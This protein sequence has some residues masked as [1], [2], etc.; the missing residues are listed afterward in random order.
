MP[1]VPISELQTRATTIITAIAGGENSNRRVGNLLLD[2]IDT[3][4]AASGGGGDVFGPAS[5]L[6]NTVVLFDGTTGKLIQDSGVLLSDIGSLA[7]NGLQKIGNTISVL[8]DGSTISV[9]G[10]G[11]K[12]ADGGI[13]DLQINASAA[14]AHSKLANLAGLSVLGRST[15]SSGAMAAITGTDGQA[16]RVSGT[17]LGF[18][19]LASG[20]LGDGIVT[21]AKFQDI[22]TDRLLGRDTAS[23]GDVEEISLDSTLE[24][25][26]SASIRRA[27]LT[28]DVT[29]SAG[30]NATTIANN[31]VTTVKI[32]DA[33][34]TL[35]KLVNLAGLS[36]LGRSANS[37]GVM[38]AI[39]GTDGQVLRVSGTTLG[40]GTIAT[41]GLADGSVT[42]AKLANGTACSLLGR[43]ANS[44]GVYADISAGTNGF[45]FLR[46]SNAVTAALLLDENVD[47]AA[48]VAG[49]KINPDFGGQTIIT[50]GGMRIGTNPADSGSI[51]IAND[52]SLVWRNA[53]NTG[54]V[55]GIRV[56][57]SD[58]VSLGTSS[59][60]LLTSSLGAFSG[61]VSA[62]STVSVGTTPAT[63]GDIRLP[64]SSSL[65]FRN[66][67]N[68][69]NVIGLSIG[70]ADEVRV[71][72]TGAVG[73]QQ[74]ATNHDFRMAGATVVSMETDRVNLGTGVLRIQFAA[75]AAS[76]LIQQVSD[77]T[78]A[79]TAKA[80]SIAAQAATGT[81]ATVGG[82]MLMQGGNA[83]NGT[84]GALDLRT[85]AGA[86]ATQA[87]E[88][89][90]RIGSVAFLDYPGTVAPATTGV[91]RAYHGSVMLAGRDNAG[92]NN[93]N[94]IRWGTVANDVLTLGD[95][96]FATV[97]LGDD[98]TLGNTSDT[99]VQVNG[100]TNRVVMG[101]GGSATLSFGASLVEFGSTPA[102]NGNIRLGHNMSLQGRDTGNAN[103]RNGVRWGATTDTW[104]FGDAA[105]ATEVLGS[106]VQVGD[107]TTMIEVA[108]LTTNREFV[109]LLLGAALTT[110]EAPANTGDKI[111]YVADATTVPTTGI[112]SGGSLLF[113]SSVMGFAGKGAGAVEVT[114][115]PRGDAT[116]VTR[117]LADLVFVDTV[118]TA[119]TTQVSI[120]EFDLSS[121]NFNGAAIDNCVL[122]VKFEC[123]GYQ[124]GGNNYSHG[125]A[126]EALVDRRSGT[127]T[128]VV[129][130]NSNSATNG[131]L[132][133]NNPPSVATI[134]ASGNVIRG[135]IAP[136]DSTSTT[137]FGKLVVMGV[138]L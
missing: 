11:T 137:W 69:A 30:S 4:N 105:V 80:F 103:N 29:A 71:G 65:Q 58:Q 61:A 59:W 13:L 84:G 132:N 63:S 66:A 38:A 10:S 90:L 104:Q 113:N 14:I 130:A 106:T 72:N 43:S 2:M 52:F 115:V 73:Y 127:T 118:V 53:A 62:A 36:V 35:A 3:L 79:V 85:G 82:L 99:W 51:R 125:V 33:N 96:P 129:V 88:F 111:I 86:S 114:I 138:A 75:T 83:T 78:V 92:S 100:S 123:V 25:T 34:V 87:G 77:S 50:T 81:G 39:T 12:V 124:N 24:F 93:R 126:V 26:G 107:S 91:I 18:G 135:R 45:V 64:A 46:R 122:K 128:V 101:H 56:N 15:N 28:G 98:V 120:V 42:L 131:I 110:T 40:F 70:S 6:D 44:S 94:L 54:N 19:T 9:S 22:A 134:S 112:P 133:V 48:A 49:T 121:A 57:A 67:A 8:V 1:V 76:A 116:T 136:F 41:A 89:F 68:S 23:T 97:V 108:N 27:A 32:L 74:S 60:L 21:F 95:T 109:S 16:L 119:A 31:A 20:A 5:S 47:P 7:G 117:K 55:T 17:T 102:T 37:S